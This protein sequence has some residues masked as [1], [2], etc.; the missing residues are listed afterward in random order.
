M[1]LLAV[2]S[3]ITLSSAYSAFEGRRSLKGGTPANELA[4]Y[5]FAVL[6]VG[7]GLFLYLL[8]FSSLLGE[9]PSH[10]VN[11]GFGSKGERSILLI[12]AVSSAGLALLLTAGLARLAST[13]KA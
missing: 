11:P 5:G 1:S 10:F 7:V 3:V 9:L 13:S 8:V 6:C 4:F 2:A 12:Y